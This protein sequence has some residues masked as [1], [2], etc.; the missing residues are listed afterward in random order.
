MTIEAGISTEAQ[1]QSDREAREGYLY[2]LG[3]LSL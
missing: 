1:A 2:L 3:W